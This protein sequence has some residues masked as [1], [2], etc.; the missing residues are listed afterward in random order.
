MLGPVITAFGLAFP[1]GGAVEDHQ[2]PHG[3]ALAAKLRARDEQV[4]DRIHYDPSDIL[5]L[6]VRTAENSDRSHVAIGLPRIN[7]NPPPARNEN[8]VVHR[9]HGQP[10][11]P[12]QLRV[13]TLDNPY[14]GFFSIRPSPERQDRLGKGIGHQ[15]LIMKRVV[16][17]VV[18]G[19]G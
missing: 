19:A 5:Q 11:R 18:H 2:R 9:I 10:A 12:A 3:R 13:G 7:Q 16:L 15:K 6:C 1:L 8:F 4:V 14:G 17:D